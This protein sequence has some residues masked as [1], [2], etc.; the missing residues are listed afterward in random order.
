VCI[1]RNKEK[2]QE[3]CELAMKNGAA[4][5]HAYPCDISDRQ[6]LEETVDAILQDL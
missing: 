5:A 3:V 6:Q 4:G 1:A 2:L